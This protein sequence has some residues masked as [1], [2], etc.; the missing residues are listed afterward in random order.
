MT[1]TESARFEELLKHLATKE[2]V[3]LVKVDVETV[4]TEMQK[5]RVELIRWLIATH[6]AAGSV[7]VG[8]MIYLVNQL[9]SKFTLLLQH[10]K[11]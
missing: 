7:L 3:L 8:V 6:L 11:P 5:L 10:W 1:D 4:R 9:D 2:D